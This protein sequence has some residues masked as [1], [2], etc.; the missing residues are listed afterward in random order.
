MSLE[1]A[2]T[3]NDTKIGDDLISGAPAIAVELNWKLSK[4]YHALQDG[5]IPGFKMGETWYSRRSSL[6]RHFDKLEEAATG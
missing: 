5:K 6:K 1:H 2:T 3:K 4:T